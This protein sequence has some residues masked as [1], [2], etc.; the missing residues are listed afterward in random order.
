MQGI[1]NE[2]SEQTPVHEWR[3]D[4]TVTA[5][6]LVREAE[7]RQKRDAAPYLRLVLADRSATVPAVLWDAGDAPALDPGDP[8]RVSG[9]FA[10]HERYGPQLTIDELSR[11]PL[12]IVPWDALLDGPTRPIAEL[13]ED[14]DRLI[15]SIQDPHLSQLIRALLD[16]ATPTGAAYRIAPA[17]KF[18]RA[19]A[20]GLRIRSCSAASSV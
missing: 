7:R 11:P 16:P 1:T 17:A 13:C 3:A 18:A 9:R 5:V 20:P 12:G 4:E 15:G 19:A 6:L 8:V 10:E 14:L 2:T